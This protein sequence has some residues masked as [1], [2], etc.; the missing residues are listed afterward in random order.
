MTFDQELSRALFGRGAEH[1]LL[2]FKQK[3][4]TVGKGVKGLNCNVTHC[5]KPESAHHFNRVMRKWYCVDCA[6]KIEASANRDGASFF[7]DL[8]SAV[9][10]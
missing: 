5:Q 10:P 6:E 4:I 9:K 2:P 3:P 1:D 7:S 8:P